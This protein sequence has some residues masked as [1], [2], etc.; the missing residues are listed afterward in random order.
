VAEQATGLEI[1]I[2]SILESQGFD[3]LRSQ[4]KAATD[5]TNEKRKADDAAN[6]SSKK[7]GEALHGLGEELLATAGAFLGVEKAFEFFKDSLK[8][9]IEGEKVMYQFAAANE[10]LAGATEKSKEENEQWLLSVQQSSGIMKNELLPAYMKLISAT[11]NVEAAQAGLQVAAG[12]AARGM[13]D[14][15]TVAQVLSRFLLN[16]DGPIRA[17]GALGLELKRLQKEGLDT[18]GILTELGQKF[19]DAGAGV[20]NNAMK[21]ARA[22]V[23]WNEFK[24]QIGQTAI[25][26][27]QYLKPA[28]EFI[29]LAIVAVI[30]GVVKLNG[31]VGILQSSMGTFFHAIVQFIEGDYKKAYATFTNGLK[32]IPK[33]FAAVGRDADKLAE[34]LTSSMNRSS[35]GLKGTAT[36]VKGLKDGLV[37]AKAAAEDFSTIM[38]RVEMQAKLAAHGEEDLQQKLIEKYEQVKK[39]YKLTGDEKLK[40]DLK[41]KESL[42]KLAELEDADVMKRQRAREQEEKKELAAADRAFKKKT[43]AHE[44]FLKLSTKDEQAYLKAVLSYYQQDLGNYT[45]T[46][47]QKEEIAEKLEAAQEELNAKQAKSNREMNAQILDSAITTLG[48]AFGIGKEIAIANAIVNT[49]EGAT[50]A[51]AQGGILGEVMAAIVIA[52]GLA[53]IATIASTNPG[54]TASTGASTASAGGGFDDPSHDFQA[55]VGGQKWARDMVDQ[56][57]AGAAAGF[58]SQMVTNDNRKYVSSNKEGNKTTNYKISAPG[59]ID[60]ANKAGMRRFVRELQVAQTLEGA[61]TPK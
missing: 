61:R 29:E 5:A 42:Q 58:K 60:S 57:S 23:E 36:V 9:A 52:T 16:P 24:E 30:V 18:K 13:G 6:E 38:T 27:L 50:K 53:E 48:N 59:F 39:Q 26:L 4:L 28:L 1:L 37:H 7:F 2:K 8:E 15:S 11:G 31:Y 34:K 21:V 19:G 25:G 43:A 12:M 55:Y 33:Q 20:D 14:V 32:D 47:E 54:T 3:Q 45:L 22:K 49:Y 46:A 51:L 44:K 10:A 41:I 56:Y 40:V 35:E 17:T